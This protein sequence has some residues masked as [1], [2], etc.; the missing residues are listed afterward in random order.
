MVVDAAIVVLENIYR[1][2]QEGLSTREAAY[3]GAKQVW[4]AIFVSALTT[5]MV[6]I[7][8]LTMEQEIG[9]LFRDI[10]V[11]ISVS[12]LLSLVVSITL[13]PALSNRLLGNQMGDEG[14][15]KFAD[16]FP[17]NLIAWI[18]NHSIGPI[19][20]GIGRGFGALIMGMTR[21]VTANRFLALVFV[22]FVTAGAGA[23][24]Y[25]LLPDTDYLPSGN[26]NLMFGVVFPPPGYNLKTM[27]EIALK[28]EN[29]VSPS[30]SWETGAESAPGEPP[31]ME[32]FFFVATQA[33]TF[34]G[35]SAVDPLRASELQPVLQRGI[36]GEPGTFGFFRQTSLFGRGIGG[37]G[38]V[39]LDISG[40]ELEV[41][42]GYAQEAFGR[43]G[44]I[45]PR[46]EGYQ[47]RPVPALTLG[48]PEVRVLPD[49]VALSD[50][51]ISALDLGNT[52]DAFNDGLRVDELTVGGELIDLMLK[53]PD[54]NVLETQGIGALP[55]VT[56][57]GTIIP[58]DSVARVRVTSG[59]T[60]IR[61]VERRRTVTLQISKPKD[62]AL[63]TV[64]QRLE[65]EVLTPMQENGLAP[66][67]RCVCRAVRTSCLKPVEIMQLDLLFA[68]VIVFLVMAVLFES[69][70][71]PLIIV[72]S[73]PL[74]MAG[75]VIGLRVLN[76]WEIQQLDT[77][78]MLG[79]VILVGI[80]V[81]NA[82]L[83][84]HQTLYNVRQEAMAARDAILAATQ[85]R[86]RPIF[87]STLTSVFGML[88]L[89][90]FPGAG[91]EIYKGLGSVVVG[92]LSLSAVLTL[93]IVPPLLAL[94]SGVMDKEQTKRGAD[95]P[96]GVE[97]PAE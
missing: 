96:T 14:G 40:P 2:R 72:F 90:L 23:T 20:N 67:F 74:A 24:A 61:H 83:V 73:V 9:Q 60:Q 18:Y 32:N 30:F 88:P 10:A 77:L 27:E 68:L 78:T 37:A 17:F 65:A 69:F 95:K 66:A 55:V 25:T 57:S 16:Y 52:V 19:L 56:R 54:F 12:V 94:F 62:A 44:Q 58:V 48:A 71:Y 26:R 64:L 36:A 41:V 1:L 39:D 28:V 3:K 85:N 91:S 76:I 92:G 7:P 38:S 49:A 80:V 15:K 5:V 86:L 50:N 45:F 47:V 4:G 81:N 59:P 22:S 51:G 42:M 84:V 34:V 63:G 93:A 8:I 53:G 75:G 97:Q 46:Q 31:K 6:F 35:A 70:L 29:T 79:F 87:M 43:I 82:I 89:V 13:I 21:V 11:A 33:R